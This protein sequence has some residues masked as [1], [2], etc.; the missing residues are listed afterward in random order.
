MYKIEAWKCEYCGK[1]YEKHHSCAMHEKYDCKKN[2][3]AFNCKDCLNFIRSK[4]LGFRGKCA[5]GYKIS[6]EQFEVC[7]DKKFI[8]ELG[9]VL[10]ELGSDDE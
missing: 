2:I 8:W 6:A 10:P 4:S 1:L 9:G 3:N 7:K 5:K